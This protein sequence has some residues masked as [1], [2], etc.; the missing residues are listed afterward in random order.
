MMGSIGRIMNFGVGADIENVGRFKNLDP[1][2]DN[3]FLERIFTRNEIEHCFSYKEA[4]SHLA[5]RYT[6][7]EAVVKALSGI[8]KSGIDYKKIEISNDRNGSPSVRIEGIG[9]NVKTY[10]SLSHCEDKAMAFA[11]AIEV[12]RNE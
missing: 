5:A 11:V 6:G 7:K 12:D 8:N 10:L 2:G 4:A 3:L 1:L 9:D